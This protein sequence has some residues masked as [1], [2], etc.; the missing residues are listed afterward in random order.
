[1]KYNA[2]MEAEELDM[3][4]FGDGDMSRIPATEIENE[5]NQDSNQPLKA[6]ISIYIYIY[7]HI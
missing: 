1:M 6:R 2:F 4:S 7:A 3:S 5:R